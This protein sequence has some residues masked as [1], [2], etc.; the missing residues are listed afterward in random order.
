[1][2]ASCAL[3]LFC[4]V[5]T[6]ATTELACATTGSTGD[7]PPCTAVGTGKQRPHKFAILEWMP[8]VEMNG[9]KPYIPMDRWKC[10]L[11]AKQ[12]V[13]IYPKYPNVHVKSIYWHKH[14][15]TYITNISYIYT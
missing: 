4:G 6:I 11:D 1:M 10:D 3:P 9:T 2:A 15:H 5:A 7:C 14:T 12:G 13:E 8:I